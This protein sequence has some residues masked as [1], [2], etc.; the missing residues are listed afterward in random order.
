VGVSPRVLQRA[1][2]I[3]IESFRE[4]DGRITAIARSGSSGTVYT[5]WADRSGA[6]Y[7]SCQGFLYTSRVCSHIAALFR[8][9]ESRGIDIS[10]FITG[11][12]EERIECFQT[13]FELFNRALMGGLPRRLMTA[14]WGAPESGKTILSLHLSFD[15][16]RF[17]GVIYVDTEGGLAS[18]VLPLWK[19]VLE[20]RYGVQAK[21]IRARVTREG[22]LVFSDIL[23]RNAFVVIDVPDI[24]DILKLHGRGARIRISDR[25]QMM[26]LP[27]PQ[28]WVEHPSECELARVIEKI[29]AKLVVYDSITNPTD[30]FGEAQENRPARKN[31]LSWW[32]VMAQSLASEYG[33]GV[34]GI[35]HQTV[36]PASQ[37]GYP[38]PT[39]GKAVRHNFKCVINVHR[40]RVRNIPVTLLRL[41]R[42]PS[43]LAR[44]WRD[45]AGYR[46]TPQGFEEVPV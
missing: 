32:L 36:N 10:D 38:A 6:M 12:A 15:L 42:H 2:R 40:G 33:L 9:A 44:L 39:G 1:E 3:R 7:C 16:L 5:V 28:F 14:F 37:Q 18:N 26:I 17:G 35:L 13:N 31:A 29:N 27:L 8:E 45:F 34:I 21:I 11:A 20:N 46:L 4:E 25:G 43:P 30:M 23:S 19:S 41:T 24:R 22:R